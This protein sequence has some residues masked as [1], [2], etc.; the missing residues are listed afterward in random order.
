MASTITAHKPIK[1]LRGNTTIIYTIVALLF[2]IIT[3]R[4]FKKE[5]R[6]GV[7]TTN[8]IVNAGAPLPVCTD[9]KSIMVQPSL[10]KDGIPYI[11]RNE[12]TTADISWPHS[13][14]NLVVD[15]YGG[16]AMYYIFQQ[17]KYINA[18]SSLSDASKHLHLEQGFTIRVSGFNG[19]IRLRL[20]KR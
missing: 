8:A 14:H 5:Y 9:A 4:Y 2:V 20:S 17:G 18:F 13:T 15:K 19:S 11:V 7:R 1:S 12:C 16:N 10:P 6:S 3:Y